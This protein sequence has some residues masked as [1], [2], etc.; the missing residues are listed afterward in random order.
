MTKTDLVK[1]VAKETGYSQKDVSEVISKTLDVIAETMKSEPVSLIGF[2]KFE[3]VEVAA[4]ES[5][6]PQNPSGAKLK[7][8]AHKSPKFRPS[9]A[10]KELVK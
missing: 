9:G 7:V 3:A 4:R 2:G 10:L 1:K 8:P 5:V 6:N